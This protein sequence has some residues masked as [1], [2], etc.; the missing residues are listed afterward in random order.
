MKRGTLRYCSTQ[1]YTDLQQQINHV[2][3]GLQHKKVPE[4]AYAGEFGF[5]NDG[6]AGP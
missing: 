1:R 6:R 2:G 5:V 4:I 3:V